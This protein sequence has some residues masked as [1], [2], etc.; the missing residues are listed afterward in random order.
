[1]GIGTQG[2]V[3]TFQHCESVLWHCPWCWKFTLSPDPTLQRALSLSIS[4]SALWS[5]SLL[6]NPLGSD[7]NCSRAKRKVRENE[8][9]GQA[10]VLHTG[11]TDLFSIYNANYW[12]CSVCSLLVL[13]YSPRG[14]AFWWLDSQWHWCQGLP[15]GT[16]TNPGK[17]PVGVDG[18]VIAAS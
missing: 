7:F 3:S 8:R 17:G 14:H 11:P 16:R 18:G 2:K 9:Q 6:I 12:W 4:Q 15:R 13:L 5:I 10:S 1:M